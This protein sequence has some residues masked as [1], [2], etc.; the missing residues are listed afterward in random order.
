MN[1]EKRIRYVCPVCGAGGAH[2]VNLQAPLCH[3]CNYSVAMQAA[4]PQQASEPVLVQGCHRSHPHENMQDTCFDTWEKTMNESEIEKD[5]MANADPMLDCVKPSQVSQP[6]AFS[7]STAYLYW[8]EGHRPTKYT[9][10]YESPPNYEALRV[11]YLQLLNRFE[12]LAKDNSAAHEYGTN[13][14]IE[15]EALKLRVAEWQRMY[16]TNRETIDKLQMECATHESSRDD[17]KEIA[18][19]SIKK[20]NDVHGSLKHWKSNH[21]DVVQRLAIA[22]QRPD[23]PVDRIPAIKEL[24]RLQDRVA[25]LEGIA[26]RTDAVITEATE[27]VIQIIAERDKLQS[28]CDSKQYKIDEL[29]FEYCPLE[30][31]FYQKVDYKKHQR[32][33]NIVIPT[34]TKDK[35]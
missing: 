27:N 17:W 18:A 26:I 12:S 30:M 25:E 11:S 22:T 4:I 10:L 5:R 34:S 2:P 9:L 15:N 14:A 6:V 32:R 3:I 16:E 35:V 19:A 31:T 20:E 23:L 13:V 29:M 28:E 7:N 33:S 24:E 21:A 1:N 8:N